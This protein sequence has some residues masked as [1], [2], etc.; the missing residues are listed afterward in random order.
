MA[1]TLIDVFYSAVERNQDRV[2]LYKQTVRW[3]P[4]SSRELYRDVIGTARSLAK[5]GIGKGDRVAILSENRPEW[6]VVDFASLLLGAVDVP[7]YPTLTGEQTVA[8]LQDSGARIAFVLHQV[9]G[10]SRQSRGLAKWSTIHSC[11]KRTPAGLAPAGS[12]CDRRQYARADRAG[13]EE[14]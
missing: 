4:I 8:I 10:Y 12:L 14:I 6:A 2:M 11:E 5:W 1:E 13:I 7:I 3:V 9:L